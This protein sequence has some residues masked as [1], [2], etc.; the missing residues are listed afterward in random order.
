M[1]D[2]QDCTDGRSCS[3][4]GH[5]LFID[6][7]MSVFSRAQ[8]FTRMD[9]MFSQVITFSD[10]GTLEEVRSLLYCERE[11]Q[12]PAI[13]I[14]AVGASGEPLED[15]VAFTALNLWNGDPQ[16]SDQFQ[17]ISLLANPLPVRPGDRVAVTIKTN[18]CLLAINPDM[19]Y[20]GGALYFDG[21]K[22]AGAM[23]FQALV[24]R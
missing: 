21:A 2:P 19:P 15:S 7:Q 10:A 20:A 4:A 14:R 17:S 5:C 6:Q 8:R 13:S 3:A 16:N 24:A 12:F 1:D 11:G 22:H 9:G 23:V 18:G